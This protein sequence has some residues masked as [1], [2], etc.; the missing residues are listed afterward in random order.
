MEI[1]NAVSPLV[2]KPAHGLKVVAT[3]DFVDTDGTERK[4][5][6]MW[7]ITKIG[8]Y[9]LGVFENLVERVEPHAITDNISLHMK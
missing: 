7:M 6:Q 8:A 4:T 2:I 9:L 3:R 5:G 1:K